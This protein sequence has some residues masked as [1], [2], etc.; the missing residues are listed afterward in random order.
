MRA[1]DLL[2][3]ALLGGIAAIIVV[4][5]REMG[6]NREARRATQATQATQKRTDTA[7]PVIQTA[8]PQGQP[9]QKPLAAAGLDVPPAELRASEEPPPVRDDAVVRQQVRDNASG[10][11]ILAILE[12]QQ[13]MLLRWPQRQ[14]DALRVHIARDVALSDWDANYPVVA[15][16]VFDEWKEA[17][18]PLRFDIVTDRV[19]SD[20]QISWI[21]RFP[22]SEGPRIGMTTKARDQS[23]WLVSA[24]VAVAT[25][26]PDGEVMSPELVAG[27]IRHE[28]GHALGL[29]HSGN[30]ADVMYPESRVNT[31]SAADRATL[32]LLY[33][34]PPGF[35]K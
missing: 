7:P 33:M 13:Q 23:G 3:L 1:R 2:P 11:Y 31:I 30:P 4:Q 14:R 29:G 6:R 27:I 8:Q 28:V 17:G 15:E 5:G 12:Q 26:G 35:V 10:T 25:H 9:A 32:H 20:I 19:G 24:E 21:D 22:A 34:L 18:F 16:R